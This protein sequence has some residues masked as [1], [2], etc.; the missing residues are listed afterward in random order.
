MTPADSKYY[1][2]LI[3]LFALEGWKT[4]ADEASQDIQVLT[5][6]LAVESDILKIREIQGRMVVLKRIRDLE[7]LTRESIE[8]IEE[9]ESM[10]SEEE[11]A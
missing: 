1:E 5:E 7:K 3:E 11:V 4:L 8:T 6:V 9:Q 2:D 10:S